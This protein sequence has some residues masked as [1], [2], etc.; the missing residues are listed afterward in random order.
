MCGARR[1]SCNSGAVRMTDLKLLS[2]DEEDLAILS[3]HLQDAVFKPVDADYS[4][5][6]GVFSI[7]VN[8]FVW[9]KAGERGGIFR[10]KKSFERRRAVLSV[11]RVRSVRSI[12]FTR[13]DREQVLNLLAVTFTRTGDGPEGRLDLVCADDATIALDVECIELQLADTGGAWETTS[14]PRHPG[15]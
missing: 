10:R 9:E 8:R 6:T 13:G 3:A 7:A 12:G 1:C 2:L 15:A 11:K 14:R 4:T 5:K